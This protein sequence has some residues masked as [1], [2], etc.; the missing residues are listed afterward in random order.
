MNTSNILD[1]NNN[2]SYK[3]SLGQNNAT[4]AKN[5][6]TYKI[7]YKIMD[8]RFFFYFTKLIS[9]SRRSIQNFYKYRTDFFNVLQASFKLF[10]LN[11]KQLNHNVCTIQTKKNHKGSKNNTQLRSFM[12]PKIITEFAKIQ[13][14]ESSYVNLKK[15]NFSKNLQG[16]LL[17]F[18]NLFLLEFKYDILG[19]KIICSGK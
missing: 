19:L 4:I 9:A 14:S 15:S 2:I 5:S 13:M 10:L 8:Q 18:I 1:T 11:Q 3:L 12:S 6:K 17:N 7:N 16:N